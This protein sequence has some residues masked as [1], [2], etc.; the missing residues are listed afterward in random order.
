MYCLKEKY[1]ELEKKYFRI[2]NDKGKKYDEL[3][4]IYNK[5]AAEKEHLEK[6][7][8]LY[9]NHTLENL[10]HLELKSLEHKILGSLDLIREK[11]NKSN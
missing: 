1:Y 11:K 10:N 7:S 2:E 8:K 3:N 9:Q 4:V 5:K 6:I